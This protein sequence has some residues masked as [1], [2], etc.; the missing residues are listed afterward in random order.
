MLGRFGFF[1]TTEQRFQCAKKRLNSQVVQEPPVL[2][3]Q[4]S[5]LELQQARQAGVGAGGTSGMAKVASAGCSW[6]YASANS[7]DGS[8]IASSCSFGSM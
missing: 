4:L 5:V 6:A 2:P 8:A 3:V 1:T 7:S